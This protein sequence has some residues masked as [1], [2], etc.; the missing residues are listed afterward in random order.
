MLFRSRYKIVSHYTDRKPEFEVESSGSVG[1]MLLVQGNS[2][3]Y[4]YDTN[5]FN[6]AD[7]AFIYEKPENTVADTLLINSWGSP[8]NIEVYREEIVKIW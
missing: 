1:A 4:K 6:N 3:F 2:I 8:L 5:N 7:S